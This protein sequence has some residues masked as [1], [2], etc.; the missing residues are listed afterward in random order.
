MNKNIIWVAVCAF[1]P[2][3]LSLASDDVVESGCKRP[4]ANTIDQE[5]GRDIILPLKAQRVR[6]RTVVDSGEVESDEPQLKFKG[7]CPAPSGSSGVLESLPRSRFYTQF[8]PVKDANE[9]A[10]ALFAR[11]VTTNSNLENIKEE[12]KNY[13]VLS[14]Q[15]KEGD[16]ANYIP[17]ITCMVSW[18]EE[19]YP[20]LIKP[21]VRIAEDNDCS[22]ENDYSDEDASSGEDASS[23][24]SED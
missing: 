4:R 7:F 16:P 12:Y 3:N 17:E 6:S 14:I 22:N 11:G 8:D 10:Q 2:L 23:P 18:F 5:V 24:V 15:N 9:T 19:I 13:L 20:N 21:F 1:V